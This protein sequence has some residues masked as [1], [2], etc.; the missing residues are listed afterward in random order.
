MDGDSQQPSEDSPEAIAAR[1]RQTWFLL[2]G[3][4]GGVLLLLFLYHWFTQPPPEPGTGATLSSRQI[5]DVAKPLVGNLRS[6]AIGGQ[7]QTAGMAVTLAEGE[8]VTTCHNLPRAGPLEVAFHDGTSKAEP[9]RL[10]R[11]LD[12][13]LLRVKTTGR[14]SAKLRSGDATSGEKVY[15]AV[16]DKGP[17]RLVETRVASLVSEPSGTALRL[18]SREGFA[19]GAAVFDRQGRLAGIVTAP[20]TLGDVTLAYSSSRIEKARERQRP[21]N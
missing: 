21:T 19:T 14:T 1:H 11:E 3:V 9:A 7:P 17:P 10:N 8:M 18:E 6:F 4:V 2:G 16:M 15:V 20:H 13:C 12:V 5:A